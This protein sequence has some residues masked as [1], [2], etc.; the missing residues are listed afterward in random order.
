MIKNDK[1]KRAIWPLGWKKHTCNETSFLRGG[2]E[3]ARESIIQLAGLEKFTGFGGAF[4][5]LVL[6]C[7]GHLVV[8]LARVGHHVVNTI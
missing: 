4:F 6:F 1:C 2:L 8:L 5:C 3:L 7:F